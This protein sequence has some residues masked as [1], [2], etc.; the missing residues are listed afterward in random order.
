VKL[1]L[2]DHYDH[3]I[4][5][6]PYLDAILRDVSGAPR[7]LNLSVDDKNALE[8]FLITLTDNSFLNDPKF[9]DPFVP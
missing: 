2:A 3:G 4:Q 7:R 6:G 1:L 5:A 8:A 9:S